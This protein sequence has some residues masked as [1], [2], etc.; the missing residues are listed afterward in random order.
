MLLKTSNFDDVVALKATS[1]VNPIE[2][3]RLAFLAGHVPDGGI[4]V[5]IGSCWGRSAS[6][7]ASALKDC[8]IN[9]MIYCVDLWDLG[10]G[11]T[12]ERHHNPGAFRQFERNLKRL[13]LWDYVMPVKSDSVKAAKTWSTP[14]DLLYVDGG[15]KYHEVLA[16]YE[17]WGK[18]VKPGGIIAF[19][20]YNHKDVR[21]MINRF[22][23][24]SKEW[25]N[26]Q[27]IERVWSAERCR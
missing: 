2:G 27:L 11:R 8:K 26:Y 6:Y 22:V 4:V 3:T 21:M 19:H 25:C 23:K 18:F 13:E 14:I 24:P 16:D 12:P 7:M 10:V 5:E 9:A 20:D 15:H 1:G 17:G